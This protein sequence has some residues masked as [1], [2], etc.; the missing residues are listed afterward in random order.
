MPIEYGRRGLSKKLHE[1]SRLPKAGD[2]AKRFAG[3]FAREQPKKK[4]CAARL[5]LRWCFVLQYCRD[6]RP[7]WSLPRCADSRAALLAELLG[8]VRLLEQPVRPE[9]G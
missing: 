4:H 6:R 8:C 9:T 2:E 7:T 5:V 3:S 1:A